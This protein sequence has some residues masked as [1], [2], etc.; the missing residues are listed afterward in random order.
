MFFVQNSS[1]DMVIVL[2]FCNLVVPDR[3]LDGGEPGRQK[4]ETT[5]IFIY[6]WTTLDSIG[7]CHGR[8]GHIILK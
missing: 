7:T 8:S 1:V 2:L 6:Y 4:L 5:K 3:E